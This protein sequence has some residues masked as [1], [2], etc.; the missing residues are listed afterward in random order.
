M[1]IRNWPL[2]KIMQ[3][4]DEVFGARW[5]VGTSATPGN[6]VVEFDISELALPN[7]AV[8]WGLT[9]IASSISTVSADV[10]L[11]LGD[12]LPASD[13]EFN[14]MELLFPALQAL[15][16]VRSSIAMSRSTALSIPNMRKPVAAQGRRLVVRFFNSNVVDMELSVTLLV[17]G[18]PSNVPDFLVNSDGEKS[19]EIIRLLR[20][21]A[22]LPE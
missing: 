4:P 19:D 10:I 22:K 21:G 15:D 6:S 12:K 2:D 3:L 8:I 16:G 9:A 5:F 20:I 18:I 17:S 7:H 1:D 13:A 14:A 11:R